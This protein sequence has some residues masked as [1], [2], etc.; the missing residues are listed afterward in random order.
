MNYFFISKD[1]LT[2][3]TKN[4]AKSNELFI[5]NLQKAIESQRGLSTTQDYNSFIHAL[6]LLTQKYF[7]PQ[8]SKRLL[9][10]KEIALVTNTTPLTEPT[11]W[12]GVTLKKVDVAKNY[13][14]K[15]LVIKK[16]GVLGFEIHKQKYERLKILEGLCI[17]LYSNHNKP[18]WKKGQIVLK[19]ADHG[20]TFEFIPG[21]EH[22]IFALTDMVIQETSTNH[23]SDLVYIFKANQL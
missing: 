18:K 17:V 4:I 6:S 10:K 8:P 1:L 14:Q 5:T 9:F 13:I 11:P 23:L 2:K 22:G 15:L 12:G 21:D 19:L 7:T 3:Q 20:D 16:M